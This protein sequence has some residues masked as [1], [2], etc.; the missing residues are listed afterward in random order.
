MTHPM[1]EGA[2][3]LGFAVRSYGDQ[4]GLAG[5][6]NTDPGRPIVEIIDELNGHLRRLGIEG[7]ESDFSVIARRSEDGTPALMPELRGW[8][9]CFPVRGGSEG[10][11][12]HIEIVERGHTSERLCLA[13]AKTWSFRN[14]CELSNAAAL[15]LGA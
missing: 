4:V 15:L 12:A 9:A 11:W 8:I 14:A 6:V 1:E 2:R 3:V 7:E 5:I 10:F 13:V